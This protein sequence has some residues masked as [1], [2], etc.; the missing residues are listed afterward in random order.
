MGDEMVQAQEER[1]GEGSLLCGH[2]NP[3]WFD[4][5]RARGMWM[6]QGR[7]RNG[8][9]SYFQH[10]ILQVRIEL[11]L[12][13]RGFLWLVVLAVVLWAHTAFSNYV[14]Y[15][16]MEQG[17]YSRQPLFDVGILYF[18]GPDMKTA[19][20]VRQVFYFLSIVPFISVAAQPL[21]VIYY[22]RTS[23]NV[24]FCIVQLLR[25]Y[26]CNYTI[27][28]VLRIISF[29]VTVLPSSGPW[30]Y[31][32]PTGT[33]DLSNPAGPQNVK[34]ILTGLNLEF[35]CADMIF[36]GHTIFVLL[37]CMTAFRYSN[38]V[39]FKIFQWLMV[40]FYA[41]FTIVARK[42]YTVDIVIALYVVPLLYAAT[43]SWRVLSEERDADLVKKVIDEYAK[44]LQ[45]RQ[46]MASS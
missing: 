8:E 39:P 34:D 26:A 15:I 31:T 36:S 24:R 21:Y 11:A 35:G 18:P 13:K 22:P 6:V 41:Y 30:C 14:Y 12:L 45:S 9:L 27:A 43:K 3:G 29:M 17:L 16:H 38:F 46:E 25:R 20:V 32:P 7:R 28:A 2:K 19:D 23:P 33:Y 10:L 40:P 44:R 37:C 5:V 1:D 4:A 42:H